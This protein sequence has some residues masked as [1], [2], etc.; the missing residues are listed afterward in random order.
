MTTMIKPNRE[1]MIATK[2]IQKAC[3]TDEGKFLGRNNIR[4][5]SRRRGE[6]RAKENRIYRRNHHR[7]RPEEEERGKGVANDGHHRKVGRGFE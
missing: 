1:V 2:G 3:R 6:Q 7:R 5:R 4:P